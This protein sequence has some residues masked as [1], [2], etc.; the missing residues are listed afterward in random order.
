MEY[1]KENGLKITKGEEPPTPMW[2]KI[3]KGVA[4]VVAV[5]VFLV[6]LFVLF[7]KRS[8]LTKKIPNRPSGP[9]NYGHG[10]GPRP[11]MT[12]PHNYPR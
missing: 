2:L 12:G 5:V 11:A 1:S 8:Q 4:I 3:V 9:V 6:L 10:M 7:K